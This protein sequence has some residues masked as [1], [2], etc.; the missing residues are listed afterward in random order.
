M[1]MV[2]VKTIVVVVLLAYLPPF[3]CC[4]QVK[5]NC[6]L[7]AFLEACLRVRQAFTEWTYLHEG[8]GVG[9]A[10]STGQVDVVFD[11]LLRQMS[12]ANTRLSIAEKL[13]RRLAKHRV[14]SGGEFVVNRINKLRLRMHTHGLD[15]L[16]GP[17]E[18]TRDYAQLADKLPE[19]FLHFQVCIFS[20]EVMN[21]VRSVG[22][23][24]YR[25]QQQASNT[26]WR[27]I[28]QAWHLFLKSYTR[29]I[30]NDDQ[31]ST[32]WSRERM[33]SIVKLRKEPTPFFVNAD[34][35]RLQVAAVQYYMAVAT[36]DSDSE[37]EVGG[38]A[39]P[40]FHK[41]EKLIKWLE[42][43]IMRLLSRTRPSSSAPSLAHRDT[44]KWNWLWELWRTVLLLGEVLE[45]AE[46]DTQYFLSEHAVPLMAYY[47]ECRSLEPGGQAFGYKA[48]EL[49]AWLKEVLGNPRLLLKVV[50]QPPH[51]HFG[52]G[53]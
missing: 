28:E 26:I 2:T 23:A 29:N 40:G 42:Q 53:L 44:D 9:W 37:I 43:R 4:P 18:G 1:R 41:V 8:F 5:E 6:Q 13:V 25:C 19:G 30:S 17:R 33:Q 27:N 14:Q 3:I 11:S 16:L 36:L 39:I 34:I 48:R 22:S 49:R 7:R 46:E 50:Q 24:S 20:Q 51:E 31:L 38:G 52:Y 10:Y 47:F 45:W 35:W 15:E 32:L 12:T 21:L